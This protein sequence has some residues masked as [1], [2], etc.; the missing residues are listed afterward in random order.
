MNKKVKTKKA[1]DSQGVV[2]KNIAKQYVGR[3][4]LKDVNVRLNKGEIVGLLGPNGA[5]KTTCFY[6]ISGFLNVDA[7]NILIDGVDVTHYPMYVRARMGIGY[8]PQENSIFR[9]LTVEEN[10]MAILEN[11]EDN[12]I[13]R[14]EML[15]SLLEE[16][17]ITHLRFSS[18]L[19]LSGGERRRLE[20]ARC[21][22][23]GPSY[24]L[25]DEPLAGVDPVSVG[26]IAELVEKL[27]DKNIGILI[28][29]HNVMETLKIVDRAYILH[30]GKILKEGKSKDIVKDKMVQKVYLGNRFNF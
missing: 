12:K 16:F 10:I 22:A 28:T 3:N 27:K 14:E 25:L 17:S 7:G 6:S 26:E 18:A 23:S 19:G 9:G 15:D 13:V 29:D 2:V 4:V 30:D 5:G 24:V 20:I 1:D 8:L 11:V 21:L